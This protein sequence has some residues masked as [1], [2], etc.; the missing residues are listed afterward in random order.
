MA[1]KDL[2]GYWIKVHEIFRDVEAPIRF[3]IL[4]TVVE[5]Q[6]TE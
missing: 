1:S 3:A 2:R 5:Y 6:C 4:P